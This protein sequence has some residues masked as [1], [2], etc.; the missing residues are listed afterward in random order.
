MATKKNIDLTKLSGWLD[1]QNKNNVTN[2]WLVPKSSTAPAQSTSTVTQ[3]SPYNPIER[4]KDATQKNTQQSQVA[5]Q[6]TQAQKWWGIAKKW[7]GWD[8]WIESGGQVWNQTTTQDVSAPIT[9]EDLITG[10]E[11][12][13]EQKLQYEQEWLQ[14]DQLNKDLLEAS[15]TVEQAQANKDYLSA[16]EQN[17]LQREWLQVQNAEIASSQRIKQAGQNLDNLRQNIA[18]IG[19]MWRPAKSMVQLEAMKNQVSIAEQTFREL[20]QVEDNLKTIQKLWVEYNAAAFEKTMS[21]LQDQ[22]DTQVSTVLQWVITDFNKEAQGI[23]TMDELNALR[24]KWLDTADTSL[25]TITNRNYLER[26]NRIEQ[27]QQ[28]IADKK[29]SIQNANTLNK[30]MSTALWYYVNGNWEAIISATTGKPI[31]TPVEPPIE[32]VFDMKLGKLIT[33][34]TWPDWQIVATVDQV[35]DQPQFSA[36]VIQS[37]ITAVQRGTMTTAQA[38]EVLPPDAQ[39]QFLWQVW[40]I[41]PQVDTKAPNIQKIWV[42]A[43]GNDLYGYYDVN[44]QSVVPV[45]WWTWAVWSGLASLIVQNDPQS[46]VDFSVQNRKWRTNLQCGELANDY[47]FKITWKNPT[48]SNRFM[49]SYSSKLTAVQSLGVS[50]TPVVWW[51]FVS[52]P[53]NNWTWHVG[54]VQSYNPDGSV[55]VLEAN[56]SWKA[57]GEPP[58]IKTY[59]STSWMTFSKAPESTGLSGVQNYAANAIWNLPDSAFK[60]SN[61]KE[62]A[63][64]SLK[65][66]SDRDIQT[67]MTNLYRDSLPQTQRTLFDTNKSVVNRLWSLGD[68]LTDEGLDLGTRT[69]ILNWWLE[70]AANKV[71]TTSNKDLQKFKTLSNDTMDLI[72][73]W[74]SGAALTEFEKEFY[75]DIFPSMSK[76]PDLNKILIETFTDAI[77]GD[78]RY[79]MSQM[80]GEENYNAIFWGTQQSDWRATQSNTTPSSLANPNAWVVSDSVNQN[81][82]NVLSELYWS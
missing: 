57:S 46:I 50:N 53:L 70:N 23:D 52:N 41:V 47:L 79:N 45:S 82:D 17:R 19:N 48:W 14:N 59:P 16:Q 10:G 56:A 9:S 29:L 54:I 78:M 74:R 61:G 13:T 72:R 3:W 80:F 33:F 8:S 24:E 35:I 60:W 20:V 75:E 27:F 22:L 69:W 5:N 28:I 63:I 11:V 76:N 2:Q 39:Q 65:W 62:N 4:R 51:L 68:M 6:Y 21:D 31:P 67:Y 30:D 15:K 43:D 44:T 49:D 25:E 64:K 58:V 32:P 71:G 1:V 7:V 12:T 73:R 37:M 66:K 42:D 36:Q 40:S 18:Y 26:Q 38:L 55:T 77:D 34:A 81:L